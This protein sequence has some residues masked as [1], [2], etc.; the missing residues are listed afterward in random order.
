MSLP[1][2]EE[3]FGH[4]SQNDAKVFIDDDGETWIV[5][6]GSGTEG[7]EVVVFE[8]ARDMFGGIVPET[9]LINIGGKRVSAQKYVEGTVAN[10]MG[11]DLFRVVRSEEAIRDLGNM[12][13]M[14]YL[15]EN[16]DRHSN[17]WI[18]SGSRVVA[19]DNGN[20]FSG[21]ILFQNA[22]RVAQRCLL[23][24]DCKWTPVLIDSISDTLSQLPTES[25]VEMANRWPEKIRHV[26]HLLGVW[27]MELERVCR[28]SR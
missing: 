16:A 25:P 14:D 23:V 24:D 10:D 15:L 2:A 6:S 7:I 9:R 11:P 26:A 21:P 4:E 1:S 12:I 28:V 18:V 20:A 27:S 17:N 19:I 5:K 22:L 3:V 13:L 8:V